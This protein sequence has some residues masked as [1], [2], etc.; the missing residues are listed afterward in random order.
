VHWT[1]VPSRLRPGV[2]DPTLIAV[3]AVDPCYAWAVG[4]ATLR[5]DSLNK[6]ITLIEKW[7]CTSLQQ[8][9]SPNP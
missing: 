5:P 1:A 8:V 6:H 3:A 7:N 4:E 9:P 2:T